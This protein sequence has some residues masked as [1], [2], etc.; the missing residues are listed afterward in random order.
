MRICRTGS[1]RQREWCPERLAYLLQQLLERAASLRRGALYVVAL[2]AFTRSRQHAARFVL[3]RAR[4]RGVAPRRELDFSPG[5]CAA[6]QVL[7][8]LLVVREDD[9]LPVG[10]PVGEEFRQPPAMLDV[11]AVDHVVE[12][13]KS[14]LFIEACRHRQK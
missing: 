12:H 11:E 9:Q 10:E 4:S 7:E 5:G 1:A 13:Q 3:R 6:A 2:Q 8:K 14:E